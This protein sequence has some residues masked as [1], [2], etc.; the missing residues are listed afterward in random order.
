MSIVAIINHKGGVAKTT[1][2]INLASN[3]SV[4][5]KK[6]LLVDLDP[7]SSATRSIFGSEDFETTVYDVM[8][9]RSKIE[10]VI[11]KSEK[12]N[13][14]VLPSEITLSG[15]DIE[16]SAHY[17]RERILKKQIDRIKKKYDIIIIDCS[18]SL[19]LLTVNAL[20]C[21][22]DVII[23]ICPEYFS[24]KGIELILQTLQ[25]LRSGLGY[26]I[27]VRGIVITRYKNRKVINKVIEDVKSSF[28][29]KVYET[30]IPDNIAVEE[31]HHHHM[32][33]HEY[34]PKSKG[35]LAYSSL[36]KEV[37]K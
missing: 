19:G 2:S 30:Y 14:D 11:V 13:F 28:G 8:I 35:A 15:I 26:K 31:A 3:W 29:I 12:F 10:D 25:N 33:L 20:I 18:P 4:S 34:D 7:Q 9:N 22:K 21:S 17:G 16:L 6:V 23:P 1:T 5:G 37:W 32:P 24:I 36:S 27:N